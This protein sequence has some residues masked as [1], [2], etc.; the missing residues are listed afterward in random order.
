M[1]IVTDTIPQQWE[2]EPRVLCLGLLSTHVVRGTSREICPLDAKKAGKKGETMI[3]SQSNQLLGVL[4]LG[5]GAGPG[6]CQIA[7]IPAGWTAVDG[8][9]VQQSTQWHPGR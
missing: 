8:Q 2:A 9:P 6:G 7:G 1:G 5:W 4:N 3:G